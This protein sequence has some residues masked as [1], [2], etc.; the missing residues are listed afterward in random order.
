[1][2]ITPALACLCFI[3]PV[4]ADEFSLS[5]KVV[6]A[7]IFNNGASITRNAS[8]ELPTGR[9]RLT[10]LVR[11]RLPDVRFDGTGEI[12][13]LATETGSASIRV[14]ADKPDALRSLEAAFETAKA[15]LRGFDAQI[16]TTKA[17][18]TA[19]ELRLEFLKSLV[20]G[21]G[22]A[23]NDG[24]QVDAATLLDVLSLVDAQAIAALAKVSEV[25]TELSALLGKRQE[26]EIEVA[27]AQ[28]AV[29]RATPTRCAIYPDGS[30]CVRVRG[31]FRHIDHRRVEP[32]THKL[33][34]HLSPRPRANG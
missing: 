18:Q 15:A 31:L 24:T 32:A 29:Q 23:A 27:Q 17:R 7:V 14:P 5:S 4:A 1:M 33:A 21:K 2:R 9:H 12:T 26:I 3:S 8:L 28:D 20:S 6:N 13:I 34:P 22:F 19:A 25:K 10:V 16:E 11:E 30:G